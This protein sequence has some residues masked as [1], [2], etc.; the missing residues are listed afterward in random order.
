VTPRLPLGSHPCNPFCLGREPKARVA[1][2]TLYAFE[3]VKHLCNL[4]SY[5]ILYI[6]PSFRLK[7]FT[8]LANFYFEV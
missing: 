5:P 6:I 1:T 7:G 3:V 4:L 2:K 8:F